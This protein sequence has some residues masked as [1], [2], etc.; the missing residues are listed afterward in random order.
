LGDRAELVDAEQQRTGGPGSVLGLA[1]DESL[2]G[3]LL[4]NGTDRVAA[5]RQRFGEVSF[6]EGRVPAGADERRAEQIVGAPRGV[7]QPVR[8]LPLPLVE[9]FGRNLAGGP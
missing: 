3:E 5:R 6:H 8:A 7:V 4:Q 2:T 9:H 1:G